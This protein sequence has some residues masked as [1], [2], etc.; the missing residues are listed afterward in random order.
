MADVLE[1]YVL[2][3]LVEV[4]YFSDSWMADDAHH[5]SLYNTSTR[6]FLSPQGWA[7]DNCFRMFS[8]RHTFMVLIDPDEYIIIKQQPVAAT[9]NATAGAAVAAAAVAA[10]GA[11]PAEGPAFGPAPD[12]PSLPAFLAPFEPY[13][14]ILVHW[15]VFGP[16]GHMRRPRGSTLEQ[17]TQCQS[18]QALQRWRQFNSIPL[19]FVKSITATRCYQRGCNPHVC[20]LKPG[21]RYVNEKFLELS[22]SVVKAVHW[23]RIAV[24]HYV[25][26][27]AED[28]KA[29]MGRGTG[30]SQFL[31]ANKAAGRTH[32]GWRYFM[33]VNASA[34]ATCLEGRSAWQRCCSPKAGGGA[35]A[36]GVGAGAGLAVAAGG[37]A[38]GGGAA[39]AGAG[40][41]GAAVG[42]SAGGG[43]GG[44][45][46]VT[47][48]AGKG[49]GMVGAAGTAGAGLGGGAGAGA[50]A[51]AVAGTGGVAV[52]SSGA[53]QTQSLGA[54]G[55]AH[56]G[57]AGAGG[58]AQGAAAAGNTAGMAGSHSGED[59]EGDGVQVGTR[60]ILE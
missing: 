35:A 42:A 18:K 37:A 4:F 8:Y 12:P 13:G 48:G 1:D 58:A 21:C 19:G 2:S 49:A 40:G 27:S 54:G 33:T 46:A 26:R 57:G 20:E 29:K 25:T 32:R 14:G 50:V 22:S 17:Y 59:V 43:G 3:S 56:A 39:G 28:Y 9:A 23:D 38:A 55:A 44:G 5:R 34:T 52:G 15:Q 60:T 11:A 36:G 31:A 10:G 45:G 51:G 16:S 24:F 53:Q 41:G 30:H 7:Y 47:A 6:A